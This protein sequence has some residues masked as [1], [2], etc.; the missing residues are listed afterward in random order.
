MS[1]VDLTIDKR[2]GNLSIRVATYLCETPEHPSYHID[3]WYPNPYYGKESDYVYDEE[4]GFYK[5]NDYHSFR[6][7][8]SCFKHPESCF[9]IASFDYDKEGFYELRYIGSRPIDYL[10]TEEEMMNFQELI[11]YG[12]EKLNGKSYDGFTT[13][14][15]VD[16]EIKFRYSTDVVVSDSYT[17]DEIKEAI[18]SKLVGDGIY[19]VEIEINDED[20]TE[21]Y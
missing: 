19:D 15:H 17:K 5:S 18:K 9:S 20:I 16:A 8:E 11:R 4:G 3:M 6:I 12:N 7:S 10:K 21:V 1:N 2:I 14:K 13:T